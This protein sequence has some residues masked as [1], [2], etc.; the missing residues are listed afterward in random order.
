MRPL[1]ALLPLLLA[2][3][4][5][6]QDLAEGVGAGRWQASVGATVRD[7]ALAMTGRLSVRLD[8]QAATAGLRRP[9]APP[10]DLRGREALIFTTLGLTFA[11]SGFPPLQPIVVLRCPGDGFVRYDRQGG[12]GVENVAWRANKV[13]LA[14]GGDGNWLRRQNGRCGD[15]R[16]VD[17][18][19]LYFR[20][21]TEGGPYRVYVDGLEFTGT[22]GGGGEVI[23]LRVLG[24]VYDPV[25]EFR[26]GG[27]L[28][29]V[30][31]G[32]DPVRMLQTA[33]GKMNQNAQGTVDFRLVGVNVLDRWPRQADDF[34]YTDESFDAA[35]RARQP[36]STAVFDYRAFF[37]ENGLEER[38]NRGE[39][40]EVW[41]ATGNTD[42][43]RTWESNMV[44]PGSYY[45]NSQ[46][47]LNVPINRAVAVMGFN[48]QHGDGSDVGHGY[49]H[50]IEDVMKRIYGG[51]WDRANPSRNAWS[52]FASTD[53][54]APGR[55]AVGNIHIPVNGQD[56]YDYANMRGVR[57]TAD[58][59]LN[60]PR[61]TGAQTVV[62]ARDWLRG[63]DPHVEYLDWF[64]ARLPHAPGRCPDGRWCNWW[65]YIVQLDRYKNGDQGQ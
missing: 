5:A 33:I 48:F 61:L 53:A 2:P 21:P 37:A 47:T 45:M 30:Y 9:L 38:V 63:G 20:A 6:A 40:D 25:I 41:L 28:H 35:F 14:G 59:W 24:V 64:Y 31:G 19:D 4:A 16:A 18:V 43:F 51:V 32:V 60:Y 29:Q 26:G 1:L 13:P 3:L 54:E 23:T 46:P 10:L 44:G 55:A 11:E 50:R 7:S 52:A 8:A 36:R 12:V 62:S 22:G 56:H 27:R 34:R 42:Y 65:R 39:V 57:S 15:L 17:A 58:D 49:G